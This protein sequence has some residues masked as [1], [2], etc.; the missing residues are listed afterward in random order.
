[1]RFKSCGVWVD[2]SLVCQGSE[3]D[4]DL[5]DDLK[6]RQINDLHFKKYNWLL[7]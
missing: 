4:W 6:Q 1:M 5:L 3:K 2:D 7:C